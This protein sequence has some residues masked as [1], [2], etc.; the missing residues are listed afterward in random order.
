M[1]V[2]VYDFDS[3]TCVVEGQKKGKQK[4]KKE[5]EKKTLCI[6]T[7]WQTPDCQTLMSI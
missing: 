1:C 2:K 3:Y 7:D 4:K 6:S 5:I